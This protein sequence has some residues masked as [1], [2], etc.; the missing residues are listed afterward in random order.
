MGFLGR[1][2]LCVLLAVR[3]KSLRA[4]R[5][6]IRRPLAISFSCRLF[7]NNLEAPPYLGLSELS[8]GYPQSSPQAE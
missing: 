2:R 5:R 8:T 6:F 4:L 1:L 3:L 7:C